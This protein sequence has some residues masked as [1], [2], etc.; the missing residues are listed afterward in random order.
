MALGFALVV[1]LT[2]VGLA[3][4]GLL[5]N[6]GVAEIQEAEDTEVAADS[7]PSVAERA[8]AAILA[9]D[10]KTLDADKDAA[11]RFMT[12][13]FAEE[14]ATTFDKTV[15]PAART[16]RATVTADVKDFS[17]IRASEDRVLVL[18][19]VDQTTRSTAHERPQLAL[20]RVEFEMVLSEG[21]WL[22][23]DISSY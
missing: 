6:P 3:A 23:N 17:P 20:N 1:L 19:F 9:Y 18:I 15:R 10:H 22:V 13:S 5:G 14:Y 7:A 11:A 4:L 12:E 21:D 8:A 16:Y 2:L